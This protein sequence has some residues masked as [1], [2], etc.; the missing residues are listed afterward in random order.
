MG[1][2]KEI[3]T[4][5]I[6]RNV[7]V[8]PLR[9]KTK[10]AFLTNWQEL[11]TT[12]L[13]KVE[14]WD[15]DYD[16]ANGACVAQARPDGVWFLEIDR[17][18]FAQQIEKETGE[19]IPATFMVRSSPGRGHFYFKQTAAS[20]AMGNRQAADADG[21]ELW[22]ARV[23]ARYVVAPGSYHPTSGL[24]YETLRDADIAEAPEWLIKWCASKGET[25]GV[26]T[27]IELDSVEPIGEGGRN[28]ALTSIAGKAR[29]V[30]GMDKEQLFDYLMSVNLKRCNPPLSEAEVRTIANSIGRYEVKESGSLVFQTPQPA[31]PEEIKPVECTAV[32]Y[33]TF[34]RWV[35]DGT[36][37]GDGL[38]K[39]VCAINSRYPEFMFMPA[40]TLMLNYLGT[41]VQIEGK[42]LIPSFFMIAIGRKGR[43]IKSSSVNDTIEYLQN[44]RL[45]DHAGPTIRAAEGRTLIWSPGSAEGLGLEMARTNCRNAVLFYDE[46]K[47]FT[48]KAGID[49]SSLQSNLLRLYGAGD[50][51]NTIKSRREQYSFAPYTYCASFI[52]NTTDQNFTPLWSKM[53]G[54]TS[55]LDD[56]FFFLYQPE[57]L[58][59]MKPYKF[60]NTV[61]G[62]VRT[63]EI[64]DKAVKQQVFRFE[65]DMLLEM[66]MQ[67]LGNR[68]I[69]RVE[70]LALYFAVD[71]GR[72]MIDDE[73]IERAV[74]LIKYEQSVKKYLTSFESTT[75]QG[76][77]QGEIIQLLQ[78]NGGVVTERQIYRVLHPERHGTWVWEKAY[79]GLINAGWIAESGSGRKGSPKQIVLLRR[80]EE[81][82]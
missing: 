3:A 31:T 77:L 28:S 7:P 79:G 82:E 46:L 70:K 34:P 47:S 59:D 65:D 52:A 29:Q 81:D 25:T 68:G 55:G 22:S 49:G 54:G 20:I 2:F 10:I 8:I 57:I 61:A 58:M 14:Q 39:P 78:R 69:D 30:M 5:L 62:A 71:T 72:D 76:Q 67:A 27:N 13:T 56:R 26:K 43:V 18:G 36:S 15:V 63:R 38:V 42:R 21:K 40:V 9:P 33:P 51:S 66:N 32:P 53:A 6:A 16:N 24:R 60:V 17:Q 12:D 80:P 1:L 64:V 23:D 11:A 19:K 50:F 41:K 75:S 48:D 73:C 35:I 74:A 4:P 37:I 44:A 45:V